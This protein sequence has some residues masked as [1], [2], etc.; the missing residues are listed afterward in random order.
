[1]K[2]YFY[3][4]Y[5]SKQEDANPYVNNFLGSIEGYVEISK[6][7]NRV[8]LPRGLDFLR[9]SFLN[10]AYIVNWLEDIDTFAFGSFQ[11]IMTIVGLLIIHLRQKKL[12]WMY[13][14]I[15]PHRG[16]TFWS[17]QIKKYLYRYADIII[18]HS[19]EAKL[20][21]EK[22][23]KNKVIYK[24]HPMS[25]LKIKE[26]NGNVDY[27]DILIWGSIYPYKG[28]YEFIRIKEIQK[29]DLTIKIVGRCKDVNLAN[30]I[31]S[32]CTNR[33]KFENRVAS[34]D[35]VAALCK[36]SSFVLFPYVGDS[37]S[38]SGVLIDTL[39]MGGI[40]V[41]PN[42]GAFADL[43]KEGC[44]ITYDNPIEI[45]TI[46]E[47]INRVDKERVREFCNNNSWSAFGQ[48]VLGLLNQK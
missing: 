41:G 6:N 9:H 15:H 48:Y 34:F 46:K 8:K 14:N 1:M 10:D 19:L 39:C 45:L 28:L 23:T 47:N 26:W 22:H 4:N 44:C 12:I 20:Y 2:L 25:E 31:Q 30:K 32:L 42:R 18:A 5:D 16:E 7:Q 36:K 17:N 29:S 43:A 21:A 37:I 40:P 27:C 3:P 35:E 33:I 13:H 11:A 24:C 38:S